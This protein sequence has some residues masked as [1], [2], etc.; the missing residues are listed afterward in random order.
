MFRFQVR[1]VSTVTSEA[2]A[3]SRKYKFSFE[4]AKNQIIKESSIDQPQDIHNYTE[5]KRPQFTSAISESEARLIPAVVA[6]HSRL[7]LPKSIPY[8]SITSCL[9]GLKDSSNVNNS[10]LSIFGANLLSYYVSEYLIANYPRLP[11]SIIRNA[12]DAFIGDLSLY[13]LSKNQ[14]GIEEDNQ[15]KL[16]RYLNG[17][18]QSFQYGKLK[19]KNIVSTPEH[20]VKKFDDEN[21]DSESIYTAHANF[22]RSL[23]SIMYAHEG[24]AF[25]KEFVHN[26][27][28]SRQIELEKMFSFRE[29]GKLLSVL[30]KSQDMAPFQIKLISETGRQSNSPIFVVGCYT[31]EELLSTAE[32]SSLKEARVKS[33]VKALLAWYLY[34][35]LETSLPSDES[36]N[37]LH[38]D[39]GE[40]FF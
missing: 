39:E 20:G 14:W 1:R 27:I 10:Q 5:Y 11:L 26:H 24:E 6:L 31:G 19:F 36:F 21:G 16:D 23:I 4:A 3:L 22:T 2:V 29:P 18:P 35:P 34:K 8:S 37:G 32:G 15:S 17:E 38:I 33:T 12:T 30:L 9:N 7:H 13:D 28:L 25:T 40:K